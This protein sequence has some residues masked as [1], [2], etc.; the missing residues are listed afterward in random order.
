[1]R[2]SGK[3]A[4]Y[5]MAYSPQHLYAK[6]EPSEHLG[7][8][9]MGIGANCMKIGICRKNCRLLAVFNMT[10]FS[11]VCKCTPELYFST[12]SIV[13]VEALK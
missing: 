2:A 12:Y 4:Q 8:G 5:F 13:H 10:F 1:M 9:E 6:N 7:S 11:S 3:F